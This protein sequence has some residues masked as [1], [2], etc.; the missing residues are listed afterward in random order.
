MTAPDLA[1]PAPR[2]SRLSATIPLHPP[3]RSL[4]RHNP[5]NTYFPYQGLLHFEDLQQSVAQA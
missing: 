4:S 1:P 2:S 5:H 3:N